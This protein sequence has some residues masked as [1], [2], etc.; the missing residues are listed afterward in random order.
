MIFSHKPSYNH[1]S[2]ASILIR[3]YYGM[4]QIAHYIFCD[5]CCHD[6]SYDHW[7]IQCQSGFVEHSIL[8]DTG[9]TGWLSYENNLKVILS[10]S[11]SFLMGFT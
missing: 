7:L 2:N 3:I 11:I 8:V 6:S 5:N 10:F 9:K 4:Y 1:V